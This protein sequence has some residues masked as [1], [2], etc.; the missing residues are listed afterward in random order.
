MFI[1]LLS[2]V[3]GSV[4]ATVGLAILFL[5][6][7]FGWMKTFQ[8]AGI[9]GW[10]AFIPILSD[11]DKFR[12]G[13]LGTKE[14]ILWFALG[15]AKN[16]FPEDGS[17]FIGIL[18]YVVGILYLMYDINMNVKVSQ[19]FG[20]GSPFGVFLWFFPFI[21]SYILGFGSSTYTKSTKNG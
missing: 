21:G 7:G 9:A 12:I 5:I 8:K 11:Y 18:A 17:Q 20:K 13:G 14:F 4:I 2:Y 19:S 1:Y 15:I 16:A 3:F 6:S 10:R